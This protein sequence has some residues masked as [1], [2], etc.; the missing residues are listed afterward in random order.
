[1]QL[2]YVTIEKMRWLS[3][4]GGCIDAGSVNGIGNLGETAD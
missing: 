1:M 3:T 2:R 4:C